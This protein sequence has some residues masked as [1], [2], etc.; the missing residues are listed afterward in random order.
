MPLFFVCPPY[1]FFVY[2]SNLRGGRY[3]AGNALTWADI[4]FFSYCEFQVRFL[5]DFT[6][7]PTL[8]DLRKRV[9]NL[10]NIKHW[11]ANRPQ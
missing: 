1:D 4:W 3:F 5:P 10:P 7:S 11:V 9:G 2:K 6:F 8:S